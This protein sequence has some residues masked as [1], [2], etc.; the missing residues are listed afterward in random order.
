[1]VS[2]SPFLGLKT[3]SVSPNGGHISVTPLG[4]H[5]IVHDLFLV[6]KSIL[7]R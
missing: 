6:F 4:Q 5:I 7:L 2:Q 1:M 3:T